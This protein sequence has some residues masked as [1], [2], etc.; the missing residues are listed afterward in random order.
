MKKFF[1]MASVIAIACASLTY[2]SCTKDYSEEIKAVNTDLAALQSKHDADIAKLEGEISTLKSG[3][4]TL[5]AAYKAADAAL[6]TAVDANAA[7]IDALQGRIKTNEDAIAALKATV[8]TL[9]TKDELA[10]AKG[11][12]ND[13]V[14]AAVAD[15]QA[16]IDATNAELAAIKEEM[17]AKAAALEAELNAVKTDV[18]EFKAATEEALA[19]IN[20]LYAI[21]SNSLRSIV[22]IP[23]LYFAGI[24]ATEYSFMDI[25]VQQYKYHMENDKQADKVQ[26]AYIFTTTSGDNPPL[27]KVTLKAGQPNRSEYKKDKKGNEIFYTLGETAVAKYHLNPSSFNVEKAEW[28]LYGA[29]YRYVTRADEELVWTPVVDAVK[30]VD[31][32]AEV[33]YHIE[34]PELLMACVDTSDSEWWHN[35]DGVVPVMKLEATL[36]DGA[37]EDDQTITSDLEAILPN[38]EEIGHLAFAKTNDYEACDWNCDFDYKDLYEAALCKNDYE[39][40]GAISWYP[41]IQWVYN[42]GNLDLAKLIAIHMEDAFGDSIEL[43]LAELNDKYDGQFSMTFDNIAYTLGDNTTS[44]DMY[45]ILTKEGMLTPAHVKTGSKPTSVPNGVGAG[46]KTGV[47]SIGRQPVIL[48]TLWHGEDI[49]LTGYFKIEYVE[50]TVNT[51]IDIPSLGKVPFICDTVSLSTNWHQFSDLVLEQVGLSYNDFTTEYEIELD[52][53]DDVEVYVEKDGEFVKTVTTK[54]KNDGTPDPAYIFDVADLY[55]P[56]DYNEDKASDGVNNAFVWHVDPQGVGEGKTQTVWVHFTKGD[57]NNIWVS[58]TAS[59]A[60][61]AHYLFGEK[62]ANEWYENMVKHC[63][64]NEPNTVL[65]NVPVP[66]ATEI[67]PVPGG[68]VTNYV[69]NLN[70]YLIG[71]KPSIKLT[72]DS[73]PIYAEIAADKDAFEFVG[74]DDIKPAVTYTFSDEQPVINGVALFT[75]DNLVLYAA[76]YVNGKMQTE[77][78]NNVDVP[79]IVAGREVANLSD[80]DNAK[81]TYLTTDIAKEL[82]NLWSYKETD[83][84][85]MLYANVDVA[86]TYGECEIP[87]GEDHFHVRFVRPLHIEA[88]AQDTPEESQVDGANIPVVNFLA[89]VTDWNNQPVLMLQDIMDA[90]GKKKIGEELVEAVIKDVNMYKYYGI[91]EIKI[92]LA[93]AVRNNVKAGERDK[94]MKLVEATPNAKLELGTVNPATG[95]FTAGSTTTVN[96]TDFDNLKELVINY[97]NN[98]AIVDAFTIKI[99]VS[100]KYFWGTIKSEFTINVKKTQDTQSGI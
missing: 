38:Y 6:K 80:A 30:S 11:E 3:L 14:D 97:K 58:L 68:D 20:E 16:K 13:K 10:S 22:F 59:V 84:N 60:E 94:F 47:S 83:E 33:S 37:S 32:I 81:L 45:A 67:N 2:T 92:D 85:K 64:V 70:D 91:H 73:D 36:L 79:K 89:E 76:N 100:Y 57:F 31:G 82:L 50:K 18:A 75:R 52:E 99:P 26:E 35:F 49:V 93:N 8:A 65:M 78:I 1:R 40:G 5:E 44:E 12:L 17:L 88:A 19:K 96:I 61:K 27:T 86:I 9:A 66:V 53:N 98:A 25:Y 4:S 63:A 23:D 42:A 90:A 24:E 95:V 51:D 69:R 39:Y 72:E 15:L 7:A 28:A 48:V 62:L 77:K 54:F 87:A 41:S 46:D 34:N 55:G 29:D 56:V 74:K 21:L 71:A 43:T